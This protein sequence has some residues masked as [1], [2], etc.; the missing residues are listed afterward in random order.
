[1]FNRIIFGLGSNLGDREFFLSEAVKRISKKLKLN[2]IKKSDIL[3]NKA[4]LLE[5][6]PK[7]WDIDFFN[8]I[9][10]ADIN[11]KTYNPLKILEIIKE[12]ELELGR[13]NILKWS[14]RE[15][16]IDILAIDELIFNYEDKLIVPHKE[17]FKRDFF[18]SGFQEIEPKIFQ[19]LLKNKKVKSNAR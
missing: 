10:S 9:V 8:I 15:I 19:N 12:V 18:I 14:P 7:S 2:D 6:S 16:D 5:G 4:L 3:Q 11:L 13:N 1:M 17:L